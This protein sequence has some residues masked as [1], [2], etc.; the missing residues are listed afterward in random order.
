MNLIF[1]DLPMSIPNHSPNMLYKDTPH[2]V[3]PPLYQ[4]RFCLMEKTLCF[5]SEG[6]QRGDL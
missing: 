5:S 2:C 3:Q 4:Q 1:C 6:V